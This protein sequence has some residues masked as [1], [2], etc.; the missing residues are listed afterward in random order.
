[1][2]YTIVNTPHPSLVFGNHVFV[3][4]LHFKHV[5]VGDC[6]FACQQYEDTPVD[7]L[8]LNSVQRQSAGVRLGQKVEAHEGELQACAA[9]LTVKV[10]GATPTATSSIKT[11]DAALLE[12]HFLETFAGQVLVPGQQLLALLEPSRARLCLRIVTGGGTVGDTTQLEVQ[13]D[14]FDVTGVAP[15]LE[16]FNFR[17]LGIGGLDEQSELLFR[18]A[19]ASRILP[20]EKLAELG[21]RHVRGVLLHGPP[22]TGKTLIA[23][24]LSQHLTGIEPKVVNGPDI[25][26]KF[27]G[28]SE[29]N[30]RELFHEAE[31]AQRL[32]RP[33]L[34]VIIFDEMDAICKTRGTISG[35]GAVGDSVVN[36]LL[37]KI[38]GVDS[39]DNILVIGLTNRID[40][41]DRALLRPGRLEVQIEVTLPDAPGRRDILEIHTRRMRESGLLCASFN[42]EALVDKT[43]NFTGAELEAV[44]KGAASHA[45]ARYDK[46]TTWRVTHADFVAALHD[47]EPMFGTPKL[48][49]AKYD[50]IDSFPD[51]SAVAW[52]EASL[53]GDH[54]RLLLTCSE[55]LSLALLTAAARGAPYTRL[56]RGCDLGHKPAAA[57][58]LALVAA[59]EDARKSAESFVVLDDVELLVAYCPSGP[60]FC[61]QTVQVL[62][63]LLQTPVDDS[64]QLYVV[65]TTPR[66]S[67]LERLG[68]AEAFDG[69]L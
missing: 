8:G 66:L 1:M 65:G 3:R 38:D 54:C 9:R 29:R 41:L 37:T 14:E 22:G 7:T 57:R 55:G 30:I 49:D 46:D 20:K 6:V 44:V 51:Q 34:H 62:K 47:V 28:E 53:L 2:A 52:L 67:V 5:K 69:S 68:L 19:F 26:D 40:L 59:F 58:T 43:K 31:Q 4:H 36:Q 64:K 11:V 23:R 18:R 27:V 61:H 12:Q 10:S 35:G 25:L 24:R 17:E 32:G 13:S 45:M 56:L 33:G 63:A 15:S 50:S 39:L 21:V 16:R 48:A 60:T 42:D